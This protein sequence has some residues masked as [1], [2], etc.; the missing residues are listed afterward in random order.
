M[1]INFL[2]AVGVCSDKRQSN[3]LANCQSVTSRK[4]LSVNETQFLQ[5][6][7]HLLEFLD[8][9][10]ARTGITAAASLEKF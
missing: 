4:D 8:F 1:E 2:I 3:S 10:T 5:V 6:Y 9:C 7:S